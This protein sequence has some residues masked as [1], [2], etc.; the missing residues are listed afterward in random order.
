MPIK[1][2]VELMAVL[3]MS[4]ISIIGIKKDRKKILETIQHMGVVE[5][6]PFE[7]GQ[8]GFE[9]LDTSVS[10]AK[11]LK[12]K[13]EAETALEILERFSPEDK[14]L[15]GF[16]HGLKR[17]S[18]E[19]YEEN[20][21]KRDEILSVAS[22]I[23]RMEKENSDLNS[24]IIKLKG[25]IEALMPWK[26]L[27][28]PMNFSGTRKTSAFLGSFSEGH[29]IESLER[30]FAEGCEK[31]QFDGLGEMVHFEIISRTETQTYVMAVCN[32]SFA[33]EVEE[34]LRHMGLTAPAVAFGD[35]PS[36]RIKK[37]E[38]E[39]REAEN[40]IE[41]NKK[42]ILDCVKYREDLKFIVDYFSMRIDKYRVIEQLGQSKNVFALTGYVPS[43]DVSLL[44]GVLNES[45]V[46][47]LKRGRLRVTMFLWH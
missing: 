26:A 4:G 15:L 21:E 17:I 46:L 28:F 45:L 25:N 29:S 43:K 44:E 6:R 20:V 33:S 11:F 19:D 14:P 30:A 24:A 13:G 27:D 42:K 2:G 16:L 1:K 38:T 36:E 10:Q 40:K 47:L 8:P 34:V 9:K 31:K 7:D 32:K 35:V 12:V 23:V 5:V 18:V 39:I 37:N 22:N 3:P 41:E